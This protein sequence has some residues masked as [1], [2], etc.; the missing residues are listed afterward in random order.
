ME[1]PVTS[2]VIGRNDA[3]ATQWATDQGTLRRIAE[4]LRGQAVPP[5]PVI[6]PFIGPPDDLERRTC[7]W[8]PALDARRQ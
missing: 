7:T 1:G 2:A 5:V 4:A 6:A 8:L 3:L